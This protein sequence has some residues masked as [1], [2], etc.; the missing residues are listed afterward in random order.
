MCLLIKLHYIY[1]LYTFTAIC[2]QPPLPNNG[3]IYPYSNRSLIIIVVCRERAHIVNCHL[4]R[5]WQ[6]NPTGLCD[7]DDESQSSPGNTSIFIL[8]H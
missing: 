4:N 5:T 1:T 6:P 8:I 3:Y 2:G 7:S